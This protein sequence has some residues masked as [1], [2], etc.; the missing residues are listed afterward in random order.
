MTTRLATRSHMQSRSIIIKC[1]DN[2]NSQTNNT[3]YVCNQ[4][5][6]YVEENKET[7][8]N[9]IL[10]LRNKLANQL[11]ENETLVSKVNKL[12]DDNKS[13]IDKVNQ[14]NEIIKHLK[15]AIEHLSAKKMY[16][17]AVSQTC[18]MNKNCTTQTENDS[19]FVKKTYINAEI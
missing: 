3:S 13:L 17:N 15:E 12:T 19:E 5:N 2:N 11:S 1:S 9:L 18:Q 8:S 6:S 7:E 4:S 14:K 16:C 10:D